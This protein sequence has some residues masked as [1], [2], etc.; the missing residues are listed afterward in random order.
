M[1]IDSLPGDFFHYADALTDDE[2]KVLARVREFCRSEIAPIALDAWTKAEFPHDIVP[3]FAA[4]DIAALPYEG[5]EGPAARRTLIGFLSL[6]L[7]HADPSLNSFFG[8]HNGL[9]M[10]SIDLCGSAEQRERWLPPMGRMEKIGAFGLTEPHGGSDVAQGLETTA[11]REGDEWVLNGE[12]RWIGNGTFADLVVVWAR[13]VT[14][15]PEKGP[16]RGFV[17]EQDNPGMTTTKIENKIALRTVQ[18]ADIVLTDCRVPE[19][20][21]L[22][23]ANSFKDTNKVLRRTRGGVAWG[24]TGTM[25][26]AYEIALDYAGER[27]QFGR[28]IAGF[29]L[30]QDLLVRMLGNVTASLGMAVRLAEMQDAGTAKDEH[31][32][33]AK[34]FT[35]T[36]MRETV[37][38]ARE[39]VGGNGVVLDYGVA[40]YFADAEAL[41]SFEGTRQINT[42]VVGRSIT[43][44]SA[45][46]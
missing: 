43:G 10:G 24:A 4:L 9:A 41:Y 33:L 23:E 20:D 26:A 15:E 39:V 44:H 27:E 40:K 21:R 13:D 2:Q 18:N 31:A 14:D 5:L 45:F 3:R 34:E 32:A 36:R 11:R 38:L 29:Q 46:V 7:A 6:E 35:T 22:Q 30:V 19:S 28:P 16:V 8:I 1:A 12:K 17:V 42:L 37:S 25:M